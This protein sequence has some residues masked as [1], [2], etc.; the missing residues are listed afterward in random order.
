MSERY[1]RCDCPRGSCLNCEGT[2]FKGDA[3]SYLEII[4]KQDWEQYRLKQARY[5]QSQDNQYSFK[6]DLKF[7]SDGLK[8]KAMELAVLALNEA[9]KQ[10]KEKQDAIQRRCEQREREK[11]LETQE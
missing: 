8:T 1:G 3:I 11:L 2:G 7:Y 6:E 10:Q 4:E 9:L 5:F